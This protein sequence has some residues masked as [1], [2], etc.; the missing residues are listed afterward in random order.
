MDLKRL[1]GV[2]LR[3]DFRISAIEVSAEPLTDAFGRAAVAQTTISG[4]E[5]RIL[6]QPGLDE[7]ELSVTLYHEVREAASVGT[8]ECPSR[9]I[10]FNEA[11][12]ERAAQSA[13]QRLGPANAANLNRML[14]EYGFWEEMKL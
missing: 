1:V 13:H 5:F 7:R 11:D 4:R 3:R 14:E 6:I 9:V 8:D 2:K 10:E 12:F